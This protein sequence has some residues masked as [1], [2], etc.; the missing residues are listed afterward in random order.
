[1]A[2]QL[3]R[4]Q[5]ALFHTCDGHRF[6]PGKADLAI[7]PDC[8]VFEDFIE[9]EDLSRA[10]EL[11][12]YRKHQYS[13]THET[14]SSPKD[15]LAQ[16]PYFY[17]LNLAWAHYAAKLDAGDAFSSDAFEWEEASGVRHDQ[18]LSASISDTI[19][20]H[21]VT[22]GMSGNTRSIA[23]VGRSNRD[24]ELGDED[25]QTLSK[26]QARIEV[27][28]AEA[29]QKQK[30]ISKKA[31]SIKQARRSDQNKLKGWEDKVEK[32][33]QSLNDHENGL[34]K[35]AEEHQEA[36]DELKRL[37]RE[38]KLLLSDF[39]LAAIKRKRDSLEQEELRIKKRK[40]ALADED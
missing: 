28:K 40:Q 16:K 33:R 31:T 1:M 8:R 22:R 2:I 14:L 7:S 20:P 4:F 37:E 3:A 29:R 38:A 30:E 18:T 19:E 36:E 6:F 10:Y 35:L 5:Q 9:I 21:T 15:G 24:R 13:F 17:P 32:L 34:A 25:K 11:F 39:D 23:K 12:T 26:A 27:S